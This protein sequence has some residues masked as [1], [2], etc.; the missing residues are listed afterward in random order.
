MLAWAI[1]PTVIVLSVARK[2]GI[3]GQGRDYL[4]L[5][6]GIPIV[7]AFVAGESSSTGVPVSVSRPW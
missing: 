5:A 7:A 4:G 6:A 3:V 2:D 1:V